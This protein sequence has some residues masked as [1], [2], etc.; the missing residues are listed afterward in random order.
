MPLPNHR[1]K[2]LSLGPLE[3]EILEIVWQLGCATVKD[4]HDR[5]LADPDRELAY[6]SVTTVLRRLTQKGWLACDKTE[7]AFTWRPLISQ[8]QAQILK[9]QEQ[10]NQFLAVGNP[11]VVAAFADSLDAASVEQL[12]AIAQRLK[13]MRQAR[14][15][16]E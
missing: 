14:Q 15:E 8:E 10:L 5:I 6:T 1:P 16:E 9:A 7:R 13:A 4:V 11:D 2:Q 12:D 3:T